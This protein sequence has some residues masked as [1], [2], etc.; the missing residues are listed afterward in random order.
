MTVRDLTLTFLFSQGDARQKSNQY[1]G[2]HFDQR[3]K[4]SVIRSN[5][6]HLILHNCRTLAV[7]FICLPKRC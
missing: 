5:Y 1:K 2:S 3:V 7:N 4:L 6:L